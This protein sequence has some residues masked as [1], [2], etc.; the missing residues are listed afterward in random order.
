MLNHVRLFVDLWTVACQAFLF[1]E[2]SREEYW[3]RV[4]FPTVSDLLDQ[5]IKPVSLVSPALTGGFFTTS[6]TWETRFIVY[7]FSIECPN[8]L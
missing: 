5:G 4:P 2:F 8:L 1:M 6:G 7:T 3:S